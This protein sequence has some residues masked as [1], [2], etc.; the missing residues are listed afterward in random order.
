MTS[1]ETSNNSYSSGSHEHQ[2]T[3]HSHKNILN[4]EIRLIRA[5]GNW[6]MGCM[7]SLA[8]NYNPEANMADG[9]C[10]YPDL[11]YDCDGNITEYVVGMEAEGGIVF[12]IDETAQHG[13]VF[14]NHPLWFDCNSS[15]EESNIIFKTSIGYGLQNTLYSS[16]LQKEHNL[17][18]CC[19][20]IDLVTGAP[21]ENRT[22]QILNLEINNYNDWFLPS[23]DELSL[24][25]EILELSNFDVYGYYSSSNMQYDYNNN[26]TF[27]NLC[28]GCQNFVDPGWDICWGSESI[29]LPIRAF[30]NWTMGCMDS[31]ACNYNPEANM[32]DGSCEFPEQGYDCDGNITE[33]VVGMEAEGG[34]VFYVDE[35]GEHGLVAALEDLTEGGNDDYGD[36]FIGYEWFQAFDFAPSYSSEGYTDWY[37]PSLEELELM[38]NTIGQGGPEGNIGEFA[39]GWYWSSDALIEVPVGLMPDAIIIGDYAWYVDFNNGNSNYYHKNINQ[40][41][42]V[43]RSF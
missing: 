11:G 18:F 17:G 42:R 29:L 7:D 20:G 8:C 1:S 41:V 6:T 36:G 31:L 3:H 10:T 23:L 38:F 26:L 34:I 33:Y 24:A 21:T 14:L 15:Y 19:D 32:A 16:H 30:G 43:I 35:T 40:R 5:F 12:Y 39:D 25:F 28:Y 2:W 37:L 4:P 22:E 13:L 9:S 27:S